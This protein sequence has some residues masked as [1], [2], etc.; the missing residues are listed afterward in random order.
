MKK[1]P[2]LRLVG[3]GE[4]DGGS[5]GVFDDLDKLRVEL[6]SAEALR[7]PSGTAGHMSCFGG[8]RSRRSPASRT[9]AR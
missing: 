8:A 3:K 5:A 7:P 4:W 1:R 6:A 9:I 2:K